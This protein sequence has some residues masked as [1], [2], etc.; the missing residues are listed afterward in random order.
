M[1]QEHF[2]AQMNR[3][4][5]AYRV[6]LPAATRAAYWLAF[7]QTSDERFAAAC[8][9]AIA[10]ERAFPPIAALK[11]LIRQRHEVALPD[12]AQLGPGNA[13]AQALAFIARDHDERERLR[14]YREAQAIERALTHHPVVLRDNGEP[15]G[16]FARAEVPV[17][18]TAQEKA[19]EFV[20]G[21][22]R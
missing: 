9:Q 21:G 12:A 3:L 19:R 22:E 16:G 14:P 10:H 15:P 6:D 2:K 1:E 8:E 5:A 11:E 20:K 13:H 18:A 7:S 17:P 4:A